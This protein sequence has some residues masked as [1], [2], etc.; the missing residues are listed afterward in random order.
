MYVFVV[1]RGY[2]AATSA[3]H[4]FDSCQGLIASRKFDA[5][6]DAELS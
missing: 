4:G 6:D 3:P 1:M 5:K 2:P